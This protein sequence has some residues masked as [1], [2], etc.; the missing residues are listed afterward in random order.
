L[1]VKK[2]VKQV[3]THRILKADFW[4]GQPTE[5]AA[6]P[7]DYIWIKEAE[8]DDYAKPRLIELLLESLP[9]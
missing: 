7:A 8:L 2:G 1:V 4:L 9:Y 3:L 5:R 6:L